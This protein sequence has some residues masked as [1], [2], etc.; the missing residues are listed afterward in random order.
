MHLPQILFIGRQTMSGFGLEQ[1]KMFGIDHHEV[2]QISWSWQKG[3]NSY[4]PLGSKSVATDKIAAIIYNAMTK[5]IFCTSNIMCSSLQTALFKRRIWSN[6]LRKCKNIQFSKS[7]KLKAKHPSI[8]DFRNT[9]IARLY[10][11]C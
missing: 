10:R 9:S 3:F 11:T 4:L 1:E 2:T 8:G 6:V 5:N 7:K